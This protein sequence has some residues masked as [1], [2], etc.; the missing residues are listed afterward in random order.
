MTEP[1]P[2][3]KRRPTERVTENGDPLARKRARPLPG[4]G[5]LSTNATD[6]ANT[7]NTAAV[8]QRASVEDA[9]RPTPRP[10]PVHS[11]QMA[12]AADSDDEPDSP[13]PEAIEIND[14]SSGDENDQ[15]KK[16]DDLTELGVYSIHLFVSRR[17]TE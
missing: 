5:R 9:P 17:H 6:V 12:E 11:D 13:R 8:A 1:R 4:N 2:G 14:I 10:R 3:R 7:T 15:T 16:E